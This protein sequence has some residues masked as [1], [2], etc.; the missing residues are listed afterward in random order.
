MGKQPYEWDEDDIQR[1]IDNQIQ[2]STNL[3][4]KRCDALIEREKHSKEKIINELSKDV[5]SFANAEGGTIIYGVIEE[6]SL[7]KEIDEGFDPTKI[8]R[9]WLENI[10]DANIKPKI[11]GLKIRQI[12]LKNKNPEKVI[13]VVYIPQSLQG[14]IQAKDCRYYQ[15]RNFKAEPMEDYQVRDVMNRL[16]YP[17][18]EPE[19]DFKAIKEMGDLHEYELILNLVNKG[20][21]TA[22]AFGMDMLFPILYSPRLEPFLLVSHTW[23]FQTENP[24]EKYYGVRFRNRES[25][26]GV[27]FPGEKKVIFGGGVGRF[28][29]KVNDKNWEESFLWKIYITTYADDMPTKKSDYPFNNFHHF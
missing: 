24:F 14:A 29:Y 15:R 5:S 28:S 10:I 13:Y 16:K 9:E 25:P 17:L 8:K 20:V 1:L 27:L 21:V 12:E 19:I 22:K 26:V 3:E 18:L 23:S 6:G 7:P 4:Y 2:E 11:D